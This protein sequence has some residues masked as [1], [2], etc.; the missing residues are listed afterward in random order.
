MCFR[1]SFTLKRTKTLMK[2]EDFKNGFKSGAFWK[3]IVLKCSISSVDR[4]KRRLL[5]TGPKIAS[6]SVVSFSV[7][8]RF[9]VEDRWKRIKRYAFSYRNALV[10]TDENQPNTQVWAKIFCFVF[11]ETKTDNFKNSLVWSGP[12][13][14][15]K[16]SWCQTKQHLADFT[17]AVFFFSI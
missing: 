14:W 10:W 17:H 8:G 1:L 7:F 2:T 5:R 9:R 6:Y 3:C 15:I 11:A 12:I 4:W 16:T 13:M